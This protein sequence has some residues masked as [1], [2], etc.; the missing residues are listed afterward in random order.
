M[1]AAR[2]RPL[3]ESAFHIGTIVSMSGSVDVRIWRRARCYRRARTCANVTRPAH[4]ICHS[5]GS[6]YLLTPY[7]YRIHLVNAAFGW[8]RRTTLDINFHS[9]YWPAEASYNFFFF[10]GSTLRVGLGKES[11]ARWGL[12]LRRRSKSGHTA[13]SGFGI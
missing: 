3:W 6:L 7:A 13:Y 8:N 2:S 10:G 12:K 9:A 4:Y 11:E 5:V 1:C